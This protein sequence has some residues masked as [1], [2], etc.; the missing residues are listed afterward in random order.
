MFFF[1]DKYKILNIIL[2]S[3]VKIFNNYYSSISQDEIA[4]IGGF[5]KTKVNRTVK[6]L[7]KK[8]IIKYN[9]YKNSTYIIEEKIIEIIN[10]L[11]EVEE[12]LNNVKI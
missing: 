4:K 10:T 11:N 9:P 3:S 1:N 6:E 2:E 12:R 8:N 7:I 5:S